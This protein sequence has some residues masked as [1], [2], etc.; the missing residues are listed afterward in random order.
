[1]CP[2]QK[3]FSAPPA[4]IPP[5]WALLL[6]VAGSLWLSWV[7]MFLGFFKKIQVFKQY[8]LLCT[9]SSHRLR[10]NQLDTTQFSSDIA[11]HK[12]ESHKCA[13][14]QRRTISSS[15]T[16][17][18]KE[19][20]I[21]S[22]FPL[23]SHIWNTTLM[24]WLTFLRMDHRFLI[25]N[26]QDLGGFSCKTNTIKKKGSIGYLIK[27]ASMETSSVLNLEEWFCLKW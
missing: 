19:H 16:P 14:T 17:F 10:F 18:K 25:Q 26:L 3:C 12:P 6:Y 9:S 1:M 23:N 8:L 11:T 7:L 20:K 22:F 5:V 4:G 15:L 24:P 13:T 2:H 21:S 27:L